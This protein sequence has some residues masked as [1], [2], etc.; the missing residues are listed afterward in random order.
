MQRGGNCL[1]DPPT[2][3]IPVR[4][5]LVSR[6]AYSG[7]WFCGPTMEM[8]MPDIG[9]QELLIVLVVALVI[10]GPKRLPDLGRSLGKGI[11]EFRNGVSGVNEHPDGADDAGQVRQVQ[12]AAGAE[13]ET[14][15]GAVAGDGLREEAEQTQKSIPA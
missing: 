8:E 3:Y 14:T 5:V 12:P 13:A 7:S 9:W 15:A 10:F 4:I 2:G 11:R 1:R 6:A